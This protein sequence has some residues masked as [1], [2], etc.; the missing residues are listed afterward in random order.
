[1]SGDN[2]NRASIMLELICNVL[3]AYPG[4]QKHLIHFSIIVR[5]EFFRSVDEAVFCGTS[6]VLLADGIPIIQIAYQLGFSCSAAFT[7]AFRFI[8]A[9]RRAIFYLNLWA[10]FRSS[11][12]AVFQ[13]G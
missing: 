10:N 8:W 6:Q 7:A 2:R 12:K 3:P 5:P 11:L 4:N 9:Q 13:S 1:M